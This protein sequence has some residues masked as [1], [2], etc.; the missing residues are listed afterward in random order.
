[1]ITIVR[2]NIE[3]TTF[4]PDA[5]DAQIYCINTSETQL[6]VDISGESFITIDEDSGE[7]A[8][9]KFS[10]RFKLAPGEV[11]LISEIAGWEWDGHVGMAIEC[12]SPID[13]QR[14]RTTYNFKSGSENYYV[15]SLGLEGRVIP[16][17]KF[18]VS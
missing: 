13:S 4:N 3:Q 12:S 6:Q 8:D 10:D 5:I 2:V 11:R 1:M 14:F 17:I 16:A 9:D 18:H 7:T 15:A